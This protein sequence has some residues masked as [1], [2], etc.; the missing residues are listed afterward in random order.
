M[1]MPAVRRASRVRPA[2]MILSKSSTLTN[3]PRV[4]EGGK[5]MLLVQEQGKV[6]TS[7]FSVAA[8]LSFSGSNQAREGRLVDA[9]AARG[10][11][12]RDNLR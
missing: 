6:V 1:L 11:E 2:S 10:D 9:L 5:V 12:G 3:C 4:S 7:F 8:S